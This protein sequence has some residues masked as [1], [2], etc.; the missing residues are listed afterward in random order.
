MRKFDLDGK[1]FGKLLVI[2]RADSIYSTTGK[3]FDGAWDC[4]CDCGNTIIVKS[5]SLTKGRRKSCGCLA[6]ISKTNTPGQKFNRLTLVSYSKGYWICKCDCGEILSVKTGRINSGNTKSCGC[7]KIDQ[8]P[9]KVLLMNKARKKY[10]CKTMSARRRWQSYKLSDEQC[11]LTFEQFYDI[12]Q[13][14]CTYCG[15]VPNNTYNYF[16]AKS[17]YKSIRDY[18]E[19]FIYNGLDRVDSTRSHT[20]DNVVP[21]CY[22]CNRA[23]NNRTVEEFTSWIKQLD[24]RAITQIELVDLPSKSKLSSV[25]AIFYGYRHDTDMTVQQFY[26]LSIRDC[27]YCGRSSYNSNY[28]NKALGDKRSSLHAKQTGDY[29]YNGLD[30][31]DPSKGHLLNNVVACCRICNFAKSN[32]SLADFNN[33]IIRIKDYQLE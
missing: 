8:Q 21:C 5:T 14:N 16:S 32:L 18:D 28:A 6:A 4:L 12:T 9:E 11:D 27:H 22:T 30:R 26:S 17:S 20:L 13:K 25:N 23:K 31:L 10:D 1:K 24:I 3:R 33:W 15:S 29:Y 2:K 19:D 7:L